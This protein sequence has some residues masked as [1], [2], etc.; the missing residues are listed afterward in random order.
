MPRGQFL[1]LNYDDL[2]RDFS[3]QIEPIEEFLERDLTSADK[4]FFTSHIGSSSIGRFREAPAD[5]F[6]GQERDAVRQLGF[7]VT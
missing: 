5:T 7:S 4:A 6:S 2:C 1:L 3:T